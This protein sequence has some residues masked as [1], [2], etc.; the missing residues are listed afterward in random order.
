MGE[1]EFDYF[2][3]DLSDVDVII[4]DPKEDEDEE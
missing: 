1:D 2:N 3:R 4:D